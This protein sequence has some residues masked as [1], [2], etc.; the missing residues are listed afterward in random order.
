MGGGD[1]GGFEGRGGEEVL[2]R[3]LGRVGWGGGEEKKL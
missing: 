2:I 3:W 1:V